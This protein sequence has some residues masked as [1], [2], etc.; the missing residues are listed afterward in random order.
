MARLARIH[1]AGL[2]TD[3]ARF[4]PVTLDFRDPQ[5]HANHAVMWLLNGGVKTTMLSFLYSTLRPHSNDWLGRHN[6]R[7]T[8]LL[9]YVKERQTGFVLLE[10]EFPAGVRRV[11]KQA[12]SKRS[13][14]RGKRMFFSLF[15]TDGALPWEKFLSPAGD[16][17][18]QRVVY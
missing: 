1:F 12:I 4:N 11:I 5:G 17:R 7:Q 18:G 2:G 13:A 3:S 10:F 16:Q 9:E 14:R 8:E 6:G 15:R